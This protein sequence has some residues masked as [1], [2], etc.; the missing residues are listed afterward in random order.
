MGQ[1][2]IYGAAFIWKTIYLVAF[3]YTVL[4]QRTKLQ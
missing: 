3:I 1:G 4:K 2:A